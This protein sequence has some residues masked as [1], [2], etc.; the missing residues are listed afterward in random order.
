MK[1]VSLTK[2]KVEAKLAVFALFLA[3][4]VAAPFYYRTCC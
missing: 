4:S 3:I 1:A 2:I